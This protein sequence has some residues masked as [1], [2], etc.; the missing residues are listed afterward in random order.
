[1][2]C[3][4]LCSVYMYIHIKYKGYEVKA[5]TALAWAKTK[6]RGISSSLCR[7]EKCS[8]ILF[9]WFGVLFHGSIVELKELKSVRQC[10]ILV[11][12]K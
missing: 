10:M 7:G 11:V 1:M 5:L 3:F 2:H 8:K 6:M 12:G 9:I 4:F